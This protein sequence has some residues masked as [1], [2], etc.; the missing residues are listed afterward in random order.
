MVQEGILLDHQILA[1]WI[2]VDRAKVE[3]IEKLPPPTTVKAVKSFLGHTGFYRHFI[4]DFSKIT[5]PLVNLLIKDMPF[6]FSNDYVQAFETFKKKLI[7][8]PIIVAP[9]WELPFKLMCDASYYAVG[10]ILGQWKNKV[11]HV[12]YYASQ[13]LMDS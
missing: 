5:K 3:I 13:T 4:K 12:I 9:N 8:A 6:N 7:S 2:E 1:K 11:L 10:A